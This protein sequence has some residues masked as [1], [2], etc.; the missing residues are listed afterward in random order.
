[1]PFQARSP[2]PSQAPHDLS[3]LLPA[4]LLHQPSEVR[5]DGGRRWPGRFRARMS[6]ASWVVS[7]S[8]TWQSALNTSALT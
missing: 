2:V 5:L 1:M 8:W 7:T 6:A 4:A 3:I